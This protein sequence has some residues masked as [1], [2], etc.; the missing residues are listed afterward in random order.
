MRI[1]VKLG[2]EP[3][4]SDYCKSAREVRLSR[5]ALREGMLGNLGQ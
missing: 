1:S 5:N 2:L 3:S 4:P